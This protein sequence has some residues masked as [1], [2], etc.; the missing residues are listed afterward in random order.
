[1]R[2]RL[3]LLAL[4]DKWRGELLVLQAGGFPGVAVTQRFLDDLDAVLNG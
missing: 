1:M 3:R 4:R 2:L